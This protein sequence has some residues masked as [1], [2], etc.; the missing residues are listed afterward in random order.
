[1]ETAE[2]EEGE[3]QTGQRRNQREQSC[4][5]VVETAEESHPPAELPKAT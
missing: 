2:K 5:T 3:G 1:M 4:A